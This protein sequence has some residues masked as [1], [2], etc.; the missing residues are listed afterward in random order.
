MG[1]VAGGLAVVLLLILALAFCAKKMRGIKGVMATSWRPPVDSVKVLSTHKV[2]KGHDVLI[3]DV[4][5]EY[6]VVGQS[7]HGMS[8][9]GR[10]PAAKVQAI[11][12]P[13]VAPSTATSGSWLSRLMGSGAPN[14]M[15]GFE[16]SL[17]ESTIAGLTREIEAGHSLAPDTDTNLRTIRPSEPAAA[18]TDVDPPAFE[19]LIQRRLEK[20]QERLASNPARR[21]P[22]LESVAVSIRDRARSLGRL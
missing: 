15:S 20:A 19:R 4:L 8:L 12:A 1:R 14:R 21:D 11:T 22:E 9:L 6:L 13:Q 5:G 18:S 3:L 16:P 10:V 2:S 7:A 17:P